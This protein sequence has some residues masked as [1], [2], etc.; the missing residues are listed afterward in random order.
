MIVALVYVATRLA[1]F[2]GAYFIWRRTLEKS[3]YQSIAQ[4]TLKRLE[5]IYFVLEC[6]RDGNFTMIYDRISFST[7]QSIPRQFEKI[8]RNYE[9]LTAISIT[10]QQSEMLASLKSLQHRLRSIKFTVGASEHSLYSFLNSPKLYAKVNFPDADDTS[11]A[12]ASASSAQSLILASLKDPESLH[13][14]LRL[15][16]F[17]EPLLFG[18]LDY[19]RID[20]MHKLQAEQVWVT[21]FDGCQIDW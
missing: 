14:F 17:R 10:P 15:L 19:M 16:H 21:S 18:S 13:D 12:L 6:I 8:I 20:L 2:P 11:Q 1:T 9:D 5:V 7:L 4:V 3:C